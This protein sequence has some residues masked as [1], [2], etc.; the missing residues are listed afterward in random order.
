M[1]F[2]IKP[3][4]AS[5]PCLIGFLLLASIPLHADAKTDFRVER[6]DS[7]SSD[8]Q[9]LVGDWV[10]ITETGIVVK[11]DGSPQTLSF[12]QLI[13]LR[14]E[15]VGEPKQGPPQNV[16]LVDGT[17]LKS[18]TVSTQDG[19][20]LSVELKG[21][22]KL[23]VPLRFVRSI[24]FQGGTA[25]SD[26]Q[27][28]GLTEQTNRSDVLVIRRGND[29]LDPIEGVVVSMDAKTLQFDLDGEVIDAPIER[30]EGV[31][32]RTAGESATSKTIKVTGKYGSEFFVSKLESGPVA[33]AIKVSLPGETIHSIPLDQIQAIAWS[34]GRVLLAQQ[35]PAESNYAAYLKSGVDPALMA[36]W[37]GPRPDGD[38]LV[39]AAGG[40]VEYRID[41]GFQSL[42]GAVIRDKSVAASSHVTV[43]IKMDGNLVWEQTLQDGRTPRGFQVP[44]AGSRRV[45]FEVVAGEDGDVGDTVRVLQPRLLK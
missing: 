43:R 45:R 25:T 9:V 30:L 42:R 26:P 19:E 38:D 7:A 39:A 10:S 36:G 34:T 5:A 18:R 15:P 35:E 12:D 1:E 2:S 8:T 24:R 14:P 44:V 41:D 21:Q 31:I 16:M 17:S 33:D 22:P 13:S 23:D 32:F 28:L 11:V 40:T 29:Q 37:F 6:S 20:V 4:W 27:W 3:K